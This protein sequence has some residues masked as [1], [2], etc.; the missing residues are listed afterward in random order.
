MLSWAAE[1]F[2]HA[3]LGDVRRTKRLVSMAA[4]AA[5]RPAGTVTRVYDRP[6]DREGAFR[7]IE[8]DR[9]SYRDVVAASRRATARRAA[10]YPF[11][12]VAV[13]GSTLTVCATGTGF[14]P[15]GTK[16]GAVGMQAMTALVVSPEGVPLGTAGQTLWSRVE[17]PSPE[18]HDDYR[19]IQERE[20]RFWLDVLDQVTDE[21]RTTAPNTIPW[22]QM[23]RGADCATVLN[24]ASRLGAMFTVRAC[25]DRRLADGR[26][27]WSALAQ[28]RRLGA[29]EIDVA[30]GFQR[31]ARRAHIDVRACRVTLR[32]A[33]GVRGRGPHVTADL[34]AVEAREQNP[35][36]DEEPIVWR[37]LTNR[38]AS[39][40]ATATEVVS[41]Y[42]RR[43]AIE[44][45]HFAWKSGFCDVERSQLRDP[46]HFAKWATFL[47]A[48]AARAERLKRLSRED[49]DLPATI[50]FSR[51]EIDAVILLRR[52]EAVSIGTS[53]TLGQVVRWIADLGGYTGPSSGG[54]PGTKVIGRALA[55]VAAAAAVLAATRSTTRSGQS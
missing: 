53:V 42:T 15:V 37:L 47:A 28:A 27:L 39:T 41:G 36:P 14:G 4:R 44:E 38:R 34:W 8:S 49:P 13:D 29:Y 2:G 3:D 54:P 1:E 40:M 35:P 55:E 17:A 23:D 16:G 7:L 5:S 31:T 26:G 30:A 50:E 24:R 25:Y 6:A 11:A 33:L 22:F 45:F 19:P 32:L 18:H 10:A 46:E 48:V 52:P 51:D 20:T 9:F 12:Y 21:F 43:W